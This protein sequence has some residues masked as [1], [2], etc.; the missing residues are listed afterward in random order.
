MNEIELKFIQKIIEDND[1]YNDTNVTYKMFTDPLAKVMFH[2]MGRAIS[3]LG[4]FKPLLHLKEL[5]EDDSRKEKFNTT[6]DYNFKITND[7]QDIINYL[8]KYKDPSIKY[9]TLEK[10]IEDAFIK[11]KLGEIANG[12]LDSLEDST[13]NI[14]E[15]VVQI[16]NKM[17]NVLL[18]SEE[19]IL[20]KNGSQ[21]TEDFIKYIES[22][23]KDLFIESGIS[24][25]DKVS[26][27]TPK[28]ALI[29]IAA[30]AKAGKLYIVFRLYIKSRLM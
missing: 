26:G 13:L 25:I 1:I 12:I 21:L 28:S 23:E 4:E 24:V 10:F 22:P 29:S 8:E 11:K 18:V 2:I 19:D 20:I 7:P 16:S 3:R 27:G 6:M 5:C 14:R 15:L 30:N 9:T 17:D